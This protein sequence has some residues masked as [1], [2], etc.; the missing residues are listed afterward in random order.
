MNN[1]ARR[2]T[3]VQKFNC[4]VA[5]NVGFF[6]CASFM[7]CCAMVNHCASFVCEMCAGAR[8]IWLE[9]QFTPRSTA[10]MGAPKEHPFRLARG[11]SLKYRDHIIRGGARWCKSGAKDQQRSHRISASHLWRPNVFFGR[12][13]IRAEHKSQMRTGCL[14]VCLCMCVCV[15]DGSMAANFIHKGVSLFSKALLVILL[16]IWCAFFFVVLMDKSDFRERHFSW[17]AIMR[18]KT[19]FKEMKIHLP[20]PYLKLVYIV[21]VQSI[22]GRIALWQYVRFTNFSDECVPLWVTI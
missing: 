18:W 4:E 10:M 19:A 17:C 1:T 5:L 11:F 9:W 20:N 22:F 16:Y 6:T 12:C 3:L 8:G 21:L 7:C 15:Y 13:F 2:T 14:F